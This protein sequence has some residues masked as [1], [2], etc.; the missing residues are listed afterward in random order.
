MILL[1][2]GHGGVIDGVYQTAGKRSP[3][4]SDGSQLFEGVFNREITSRLK[5]LC[6]N[7]NIH[8]KIIVPEL[9]DISLSERTRRVN[10]IYRTNKNAI[11]I[12]VHANAF[13]K[14]S[15]NG[16]SIY[17]SNGLTK[18]DAIAEIIA[19]EYLKEMTE[20]RD[21]G[22]KEAAFYMVRR[23]HCPAVLIECAFMTNERECKILMTE[24]DRIAKAIFNGIL[25]LTK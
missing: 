20:F 8:C 24:Q 19:N 3:I 12:S 14:E 1:D 23:T 4:W 13:K 2:N 16:F 7:S 21:R 25:K 5:E 17:T 15:A 6:D 11:L 18:S 9:E 22:K 10:N